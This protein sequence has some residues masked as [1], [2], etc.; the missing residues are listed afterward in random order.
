MIFLDT[1]V[2]IWWLGN[3][4]KLSKKAL[5]EIKNAHQQKS[6]YISAITIWEI[7]LLVKKKRLKLSM[8]YDEWIKKVMKISS[9]KITDI[10]YKIAEKSVFMDGFEGHDPADRM[11]I[12]SC[13]SLDSYLISADRKIRNCKQIKTIW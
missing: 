1:H 13:L 8:D 3:Q 9:I 4:E 2:L 5:A 12:A 11:I 6:I 7:A 10:N